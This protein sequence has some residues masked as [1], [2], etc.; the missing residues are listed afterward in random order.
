MIHPI[1]SG[2]SSIPRVICVIMRMRFQEHDRRSRQEI[3]FWHSSF[4]CFSNTYTSKKKKEKF[5]VDY[6]YFGVEGVKGTLRQTL[7]N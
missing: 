3:L 2:T 1:A 5:Q 7:K 4:Y 6:Y